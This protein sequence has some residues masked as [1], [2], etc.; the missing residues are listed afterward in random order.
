VD[1]ALPILE[2]LQQVSDA[3]KGSEFKADVDAG[4]FGR[5]EKFTWLSFD[6]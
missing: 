6:D 5:P 4:R 3:G 2:A 1:P